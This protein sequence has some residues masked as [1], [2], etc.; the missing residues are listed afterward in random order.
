[1]EMVLSWFVDEIFN[2][3]GEFGI[4]EEFRHWTLCGLKFNCLNQDCH[5][6]ASDENVAVA[7]VVHCWTN[8][9]SVGSS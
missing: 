7:M 3:H 2:G 4:A 8:M 9:P 1:M 6:C 5:L